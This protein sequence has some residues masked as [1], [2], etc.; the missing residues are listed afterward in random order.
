MKEDNNEDT[1]NDNFLEDLQASISK[2]E[3]QPTH[4][5]PEASSIPV[6]SQGDAAQSKQDGENSESESIK[7]N[8]KSRRS[9][10]VLGLIVIACIASYA[11]N[12]FGKPSNTSQDKLDDDSIQVTDIPETNPVVP[13]SN[14]AIKA[15]PELIDTE[16]ELV[17]PVRVLDSDVASDIEND[18]SNIHLD[19]VESE[20]LS[21]LLV[22]ITET[23]EL[24]K[25]DFQDDN[26]QMGSVVS[27]QDISD[28]NTKIT[29]H[30]SQIDELSRLFREFRANSITKIS[31]LENEVSKKR[32]DLSF[33]KDRPEISNLIISRALGKC[34]SCV[35]HASFKYNDTVIQKANGQ[36]WMSFKISIIGDRLTL[37]KGDVV[38]D[39]W[40]TFKSPAS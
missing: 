9:S 39:Y 33:E 10:K 21:K 3:E 12:P 18:E 29:S 2:D 36:T 17:S 25:I 35:Q 27:D 4:S 15:V 6:N 16:H 38:Y 40:S 37:V 32:Y 24:P 20:E 31:M 34:E 23:I 5:I 13:D 14:E 30:E 26:V 1:Q 28:I 11:F 8:S 19:A 22:G 7:A